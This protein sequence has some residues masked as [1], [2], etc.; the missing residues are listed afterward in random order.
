[1]TELGR[2]NETRPVAIRPE[3][4]DQDRLVDGRAPVAT[5]TL[6]R[7]ANAGRH[8][9]YTMA[10]AGIPARVQLNHGDQADDADRLRN[11]AESLL[12]P[13]EPLE[14]E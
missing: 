9:H 10:V 1:M 5:S 4:I 14:I 12:A 11:I 2:I 8:R 3:R 7:T 6:T 13:D